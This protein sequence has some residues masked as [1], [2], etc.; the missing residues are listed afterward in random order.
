[1]PADT[2]ERLSEERLAYFNCPTPETRCS[3]CPRSRFTGTEKDCAWP[4]TDSES[5]ELH[6]ALL[7]ERA[8]CKRLDAMVDVLAK[9]VSSEGDCPKD[10]HEWCPHNCESHYGVCSA[11]TPQAG[12]AQACDYDAPDCWRYW[13]E[14]EV[15]HA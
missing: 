2:P 15:P 6:D 11:G 5:E 4:V 14:S 10:V 9:F 1:M 12:V 7:A 3:E 13:A 8:E